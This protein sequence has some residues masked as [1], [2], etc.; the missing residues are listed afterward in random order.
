MDEITILEA[1][2]QLG[3]S[4]QTIYKKL[5]LVP[6]KHIKIKDNIK[7]LT[8]EAVEIIGNSLKSKSTGT[9]DN[10]KMF[11]DI[12][13]IYEG[14]IQDLQIQNNYLR[15][16]LRTKNKLLEERDSLLKNMQVL[17]NSYNNRL[18]VDN[19]DKNRRKQWWK[20]WA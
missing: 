5:D 9:R 15:A 14:R 10:S 13:K 4:K 20:F 11:D 8:P 6:K 18:L 19:I 17:L 1:A 16:K 12:S 3:I 2:Q 7:Y